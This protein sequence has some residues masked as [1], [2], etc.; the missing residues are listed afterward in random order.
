[1]RTL[2]AMRLRLPVLALLA[3]LGSGTAGAQIENGSFE[4]GD[5]TGWTTADL[6][7]PLQALAVVPENT[8]GFFIVLSAPTDGEFS[9]VTGFAGDEAGTIT[10]A[11]EV[12]IPKATPVLL[13][14][15]LM[16]WDLVAG[17]TES[18]LDRTFRVVVQPVGGGSEL[19]SFELVRAAAETVNIGTTRVT[20]SVDLADFADQTVQ[21]QLEWDVPEGDTGPGFVDLDNVRLVGKKVPALDAASLKL[22]LNFAKPASDSVKLDL[23]V[24]VMPGFLPQ[25]ELVTVTVGNIGKVFTLDDGGSAQVGSDKAKLSTVSGQPDHRRLVLSY[26]KGDFDDDVAPYGLLD[27]TTGKAGVTLNLPVTVELDGITTE[28]TFLVLYKATATK[29]GKASAKEASELWTAK[30]QVKLDLAT[31]DSDTLSLTTAALTGAGFEPL[32]EEIVLEIGGVT[33]A[34]T[35]GADG[36]AVD[37]EDSIAIVR[38]SKNPARQKVSFKS[39]AGSFAAV[40]ELFVNEDTPSGGVAAQVPVSVTLDGRTA[41]IIVPVIYKAKAG[42]TGSAKG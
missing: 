1:M 21:L 29:S 2:S 40:S 31:A 15:Y 30:L 5:F 27:L 28:R 34:F 13:L 23:I 8:L 26:A 20:A 33:R 3:G 7:S 17:A 19:A 14:D 38:D 35:L 25:G 41:K 12:T 11:Q 37:G 6:A 18:T 4:T 16:Q 42:K 10:L 24:P 39:K 36:K 32:G 22:S 9:V